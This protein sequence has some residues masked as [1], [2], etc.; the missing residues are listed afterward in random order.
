ME[1]CI[2]ITILVKTYTA[3]RRQAYLNATKTSLLS[4]CRRI[5]N[6]TGG[7]VKCR[8]KLPMADCSELALMADRCRS[9]APESG[10]LHFNTSTNSQ[11]HSF[12]A[13]NGHVAPAACTSNK[14]NQRR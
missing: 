3:H 14:H 5:S 11:A 8:V 13:P 6:H 1:W 4:C 10:P 2:N 7:F 12:H 9:A